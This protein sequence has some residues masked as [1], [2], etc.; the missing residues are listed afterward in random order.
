MINTVSEGLA[1]PRKRRQLAPSVNVS[2]DSFYKSCQLQHHTTS[3]LE[4]EILVKQQ[5]SLVNLSLSLERRMFSLTSQQV[6]QRTERKKA[7]WCPILAWVCFHGGGKYCVRSTALNTCV[8]RFLKMSQE[9]VRVRSLP[10]LSPLMVC[11]TSEGLLNFCSLV[12][13]HHLINHLQELPIAIGSSPTENECESR[14]SR[15]LPS[16]NLKEP[17][18]PVV[19]GG[20]REPSSAT[21]R[22]DWPS[23]STDS[24]ASFHC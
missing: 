1:T 6:D 12:C 20:L 23:L 11:R 8:R 5:T 19:A 15:L 21:F 7:A 18:L 9:P 10:D 24:S 16:Q 3:G 14:R 22:N 13:R 4:P 17:V 2:V